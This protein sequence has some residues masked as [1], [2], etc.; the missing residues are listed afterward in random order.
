[1]EDKRFEF[2]TVI[3]DTVNLCNLDK[4][5]MA[6]MNLVLDGKKI[7]LFGRRNTGK[8]SLLESF[9]IPQW[10]RKTNQAFIY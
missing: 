8:T 6:I 10:L 1:M 9:V 5:K 2:E 3:K 7:L 4:E